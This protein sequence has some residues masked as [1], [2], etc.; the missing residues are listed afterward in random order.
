MMNVK[1]F[2]KFLQEQSVFEDTLNRLDQLRGERERVSQF[3]LAVLKK[4]EH[5][6]I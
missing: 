4:E 6:Q 5:T 3:M 1:M 2:V